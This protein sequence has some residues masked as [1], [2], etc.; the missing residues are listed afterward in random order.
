MTKPKKLGMQ[1]S[2]GAQNRQ[3]WKQIIGARQQGDQRT[4]FRPGLSMH[5]AHACPKRTPR[6]T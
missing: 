3:K 2:C 4:F 5:D 1:I 6:N